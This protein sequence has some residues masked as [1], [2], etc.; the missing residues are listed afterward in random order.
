[1]NQLPTRG[2]PGATH[3]GPFFLPAILGGLLICTAFP[4]HG[5]SAARTAARAPATLAAT[6]AALPVPEAH[7]VVGLASQP[8]ARWNGPG[9]GPPAQAAKTIALLAEDLRNGGILGVA[10]GVREAARTIGWNV[11][12]FDAKGTPAGRAKAFADALESKPDGL[13]LCGADALENKAALESFAARHVPVVGWHSGARPGPV[14][15]GLVATNITTDPLEVA[16]VTALAAVLQSGGRAGV[17]VF[18]DSRFEIATAK[19]DAMAQVIRACTGCTLLEVRDVAISDS[20]ARMPAVTRALLDR[21]G[22]R[23]THALAINDIYFDY[24][25]PALTAAGLPGHRLSLLSAGDGSASAFLRIQARTFQAGTVAE[26]LNLQGWQA[27]DELNRL[28]ARQSVSGYMAPVHLVTAENLAFDGG[29]NL[30]YD[31]D[32]GYRDVYRR[33][34]KP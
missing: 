10:Q 13:V 15:G 3:S 4:G 6:S 16:R 32:N 30:S 23:W 9:S 12:I 17:V 22:P 18:T 1:V 21:Y 29:K 11:S 27:V 25:V 31:P 33:I 20:A 19:A 24:A 7:Q 8:G 5:Q 14:A 34:W 26:P 2:Q 28:F